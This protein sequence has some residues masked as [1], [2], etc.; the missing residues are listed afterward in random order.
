MKS[1][2]RAGLNYFPTD[3]R[4]R[5]HRDLLIAREQRTRR[6]TAPLLMTPP[7][8]SATL[9]RTLEYGAKQISYGINPHLY[10]AVFSS[11]LLRICVSS[12]MFASTVEFFIALSNSTTLIF[13]DLLI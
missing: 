10:S 3:A 12:G 2:R 11:S 7:A 1:P 5:R 6:S 8:T 4:S 9:L 13:S